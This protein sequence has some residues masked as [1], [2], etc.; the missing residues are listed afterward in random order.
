MPHMHRFHITQPAETGA[1]ATLQGPEAHHALNAV[2]VRPGDR[3]H[4]FDGRG[5]QGEAS[6]T[7]ASRHHVD[8]E[9][10]DVHRAPP[11]RYQLAL[12]QACLNR[13]APTEDLIRRCTE[14]GVTQFVFYQGQHSDRAPKHQDKWERWAIESCKQCGRLWLP[15]FSVAP[16]LTDALHGLPQ[17]LVVATMAMKA[18]PLREVV[19]ASSATLAVGPEGG[20][21]PEELTLLTRHGGHPTSLGV[22]TLRSEIAAMVASALLLYEM[23]ELGP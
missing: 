13:G 10:L 12:L 6:V 2:R 19:D 16:T 20:F 22:H 1:I 15:E 23:G 5:W 17:P 4:L 11:P 7:R 18:R 14:I 8:A 3:I 21:H 9:V